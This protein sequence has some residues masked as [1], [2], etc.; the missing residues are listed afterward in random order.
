MRIVS[1][2]HSCVGVPFKIKVE[3][4]AEE[5]IVTWTGENIAFTPAVGIEVEA[6]VTAAG[7]V[8]VNVECC[9]LIE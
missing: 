3:D 7:P 4:C 5:S 9:E 2:S 8:I 1:P 6:V